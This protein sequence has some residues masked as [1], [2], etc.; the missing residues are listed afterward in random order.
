MSGRDWMPV[1]TLER[2]VLTSSNMSSHAWV[3]QRSVPGNIPAMQFACFCGSARAPCPQS[4]PRYKFHIGHPWHLTPLVPVCKW[5]STDK[6]YAPPL[7]RSAFIHTCIP[8]MC[9]EEPCMRHG[10]GEADDNA[11]LAI[12]AARVY[13]QI[14]TVIRRVCDNRGRYRNVWIQ[15][16]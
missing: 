7:F 12:K 14:I 6:I 4:W 2:G 13:E 1:L 10:G 3:C 16:K 15:E 11:G 9:I 8:Q 5:V